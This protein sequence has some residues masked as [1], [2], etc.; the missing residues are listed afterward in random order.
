MAFLEHQS[1]IPAGLELNFSKFSNL[2]KESAHL[3]FGKAG[4][5][6]FRETVEKKDRQLIG[7]L[8]L[9]HYK[10]QYI[11]SEIIFENNRDTLELANIQSPIELISLLKKHPD[12]CIQHK[13]EFAKAP[14]LIF[15]TGDPVAQIKALLAELSPISGEGLANAY[16]QRY[17]LK[18]STVK[19]RLLKEVS[20]YVRNGVYDMRTRVFTEKQLAALSSKLTNPWYFTADVERIFQRHIKKLY[21]EYM[22][23]QNLL[24]LGYRKTSAVVYASQYSSL[25][26]CLLQTQW[27]GETFSVSDDLWGIPQIY[28]SLQKKANAL[29]L[30][31]YA[32]QKYIRLSYLKRN[33]VHKKD[34]QLFIQTISQQVDDEAFFTLK[35]LQDAGLTFTLEHLG[36]EDTFY[37]SILKQGKKI[38]AKRFSGVYL[39]RKSKGDI[40][41]LGFI[42][43]LME[44]LLSIDLFDLSAMIHQQY[45]LQLSPTYIRNI[46]N[47]SEIYYDD[48]SE[49]LFLDYDTYFSS[50]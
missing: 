38:Q 19:V 28:S 5:V 18:S 6:R 42:S 9:S 10:N 14:F 13:I 40:S 25:F 37:S 26:D 11:S 49:K 3:I 31:E 23:T 35:S 12:I 27:V 1:P 44:S 24:Q 20:Q 36:F 39:F 15:G 7:K 50:I 2:L 48:I 46:T 32:P 8:K 29:E 34:L 16:H 30:I 41:L 22:S 33:G 4:Y 43:Y 45:G 47:G 17:G 21:Q